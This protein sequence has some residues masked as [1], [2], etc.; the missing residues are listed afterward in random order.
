MRSKS[1]TKLEQSLKSVELSS[2]KNNKLFVVFYLL[3]VYIF[4]SV[5]GTTDKMLLL[6]TDTFK[7]PLIGFDLNIIYFY[8]L[9]P[10]IL[11]ILHFNLLFHYHEH[12]KR[13]NAY[14]EKFAIETV[15]SSMYNYVYISLKN[16]SKKGSAMRILLWILIYLFP[17]LVFVSIFQRFADYHHNTITSLHLLIIWIDIILICR[18]IYV[19]T[20]YFKPTWFSALF[21]GLIVSVGILESLFFIYFFYPLV[22]NSE[23]FTPITNYEEMDSYA[24]SVCNMHYL[25][26]ESQGNKA[27]RCYPRIIVR[28][29]KI[30]KI[31][32]S[33][34]YIPRYIVKEEHAE[35]LKERERE[36][37]L[38]LEYG[39]RIDLSNRNLRYADLE[40][41]ILTR[42]DMHNTQLQGGNLKKT[43]LQAVKL[44]NAKLQGANMMSAKL[45][46]A[47]VLNA[48]LQGASLIAA[49]M[50]DAYFDESNL[51]KV[52]MMGA[53]LKNTSFDKSDLSDVDMRGV[54]NRTKKQTGG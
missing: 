43:H 19:N 46:G 3:T 26:L 29:E 17:L 45:Q 8:V 5:L 16:G 23:T 36:K 33:T 49:D 38:I 28:D 48:Q 44:D 24:K 32:P 11:L 34:L 18:C 15:D 35:A 41:C 1:D 27:Q 50:S 37:R 10:L 47:R 25:F 31:S 39:E 12:L 14:K 4:V 40:N 20:V 52:R 30:S 22:K 21:A 6:P 7:M 13:L 42:A 54:K 51:S 53:D 2:S 9:A